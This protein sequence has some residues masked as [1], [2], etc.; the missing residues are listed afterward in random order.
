MFLI[1]YGTKARGAGG[2]AIAMPQDSIAGAVNPATIS[3]VESRAD[4]GAD[5]F[6]PTAKT[7]LGIESEESQANLFAMPAMGGVYGFNRKVSMGFSAVPYGGGGS[8]YNT[9][10]YNA[11]PPASNTDATLGVNL[12]V[13]QMNPTVSY[14]VNK[15]NSIGA[16]LV[17]SVQ[18]F[19]AF[20]LNY[21]ETFTQSFIDNAG[22][23]THLTNNGNDWA[24][25]AGTR[26]GWM[27]NFMDKKLSLGAVYSS[28]VFMTKFDKYSDLFAEQGDLDTPANMGV[29]ISYKFT[30]K[31][32]LG[33][34]VTHTLYE[35]V[36]SIGNASATKGPGS[37]YPNADEKH[38]LGNPEGL[39]FGWNNQTVFKL[40]AIYDYDDRWTLRAG[41]NYGESPIDETNGEILMSIVAPA[42]TQNH[43][44]LGAT[45]SP[46]TRTEWSFS[47]VHSFEFEQ[48]GPTYI[49]GTG[50]LSMYQNALGVSFGYKI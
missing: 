27:G 49:G 6:V 3:F 8:R 16:T 13:M 17:F 31:L 47:Y 20:G 44:T 37:I 11:Q 25:G 45:Y 30:P 9:N 15:Q 18:T 40:G 32:T 10:L 23:V 7:D 12:M 26:I 28:R 33:L 50:E 48:R 41:W 22:S 2:V 19:R 21:F 38:R 34:D 42:V 29:G 5:I 43:L 24:Y 1:G 46:T 14:K 4:V 35:D 39:G 36:A